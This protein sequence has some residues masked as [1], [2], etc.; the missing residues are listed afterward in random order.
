[1]EK[2]RFFIIIYTLYKIVKTRGK[3]IKIYTL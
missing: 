2:N 3:N 1:M